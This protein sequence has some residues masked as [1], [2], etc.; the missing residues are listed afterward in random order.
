M[1]RPRDLLFADA[2]PLE[3][4]D[5]VIDARGHVEW[6]IPFRVAVVPN[7][8]LAD[9]IRAETRSRWDEV[10]SVYL[11]TGSRSGKL[12]VRGQKSTTMRDLIS[13]TSLIQEHA[14]KAIELR[15]EKLVAEVL[16]GYDK[17][18][19]GDLTYSNRND[20]VKVACRHMIDFPANVFYDYEVLNNPDSPDTQPNSE[21]A[22]D[23]VTQLDSIAAQLEHLEAERSAIAPAALGR[24]ATAS[25]AFDAAKSE[26]DEAV[27]IAR[28]VGVTWA[29]IGAEVGITQQAAQQRWGT[30]VK[31][32]SQR[33]SD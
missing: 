22:H 5:R 17:M 24:V 2:P 12:V 19:L 20:M 30:K 14:N 4:V 32:A 11:P 7:R 31:N 15:H 29:A 3:A 8:A 25:A 18:E 9:A 6:R 26:L 16:A 33:Q 13:L 21:H 23:I 1:R 28:K 27:V 10:R